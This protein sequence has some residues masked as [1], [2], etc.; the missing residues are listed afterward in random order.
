MEWGLG[1]F[2]VPIIGN[3][4]PTSYVLLSF[5][6]FVTFGIAFLLASRDR[7]RTKA[8]EVGMTLKPRFLRASVIRALTIVL[9]FAIVAEV[10]FLRR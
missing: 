1:G 2:H 9:P 4:V 8:R 3:Y 10:P 6:G 7:I 5:W